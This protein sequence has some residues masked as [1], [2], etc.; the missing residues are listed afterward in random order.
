[1]RRQLAILFFSALAS[2]ASAQPREGGF[3]ALAYASIQ[4]VCIP[5]LRGQK[6][7]GSLA[8]EQAF[9]AAQ[10]LKTGI[11]SDQLALFPPPHD[12]TLS[13]A[14]LISGERNGSR[15]VLAIGGAEPSCRLFVEQRAGES[16]PAGDLAKLFSRAD[17]WQPANIPASA[18][19][20][21]GFVGG[22]P[23][24]PNAIALI[25]LTN[26]LPGIAYTAVIEA[27]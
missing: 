1:M 14:T 19:P 10:G 16:R 9:V 23:E 17:G 24:R 13:R 3:E 21:L 8:E 12:S 5:L 11:S 4:N 2:S 7:L 22:N 27:R 26:Q 20:R 15:F 25:L 18:T 6:R